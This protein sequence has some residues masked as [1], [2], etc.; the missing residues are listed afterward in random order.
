MRKLRVRPVVGITALS[1]GAG[2][3]G[4]AVGSPGLQQAGATSAKFISPAINI[5]MGGYLVEQL[6]GLR[7]RK[8]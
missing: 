3:V 5:T 4:D 2:I 7:R 8:K 6:R 1:V